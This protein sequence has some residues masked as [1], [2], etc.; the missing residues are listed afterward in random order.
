MYKI[1]YFLTRAG[2]R[3]ES[4]S[5]NLRLSPIFHKKIEEKNVEPKKRAP[6]CSPKNGASRIRK[7]EEKIKGFAVYNFPEKDSK[8]FG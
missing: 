7:Q 3:S 5:R 4:K 6:L 2:P 1:N 8:F